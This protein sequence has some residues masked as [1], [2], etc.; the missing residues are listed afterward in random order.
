MN[1]DSRNTEYVIEIEEDTRM[2]EEILS[3]NI[4]V[5]S[6]DTLDEVEVEQEV[7]EE[8]RPR[9]E[10]AVYDFLETAE[11]RWQEI[12]LLILKAEENKNNTDF[13][14]AL[15][16]ATII[17]MAAQLEGYVKDLI[18][19]IISDLNDNVEFEVLPKDM[20]KTYI[21]YFVDNDNNHK[22]NSLQ[23]V[24]KEFRV[25]LQA[26]PFLLDHKNTAPG[27]IEKYVK[28]FGIEDFFS[29]LHN[30][31]LDILFENEVEDSNKLIEEFKSYLVKKIKNFPYKTELDKYKLVK[32]S[33]R[34]NKRNRE[35]FLWVN[36][37]D[38]LMQARHS[39][40]HGSLF[41]NN[42]TIETL[43]DYKRKSKI[44]QYSIATIL[45]NK[46]CSGNSDN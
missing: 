10:T 41:N 18:K 2:E 17:L 23:D 15:C 1:L 26:A 37:L 34:V 32:D 12:E 44:L 40:A 6:D 28:N 8:H 30:S 29:Y 11:D 35:D 36:F 7:N 25:K 5:E 20:K 38:N 16:R 3:D 22:I 24:F 14:D 13:Y 46:V 19:A 9:I 4:L 45:T 42:L 39:V 21:K 43:K 33:I 31:A 27:I